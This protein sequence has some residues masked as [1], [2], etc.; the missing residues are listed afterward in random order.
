MVLSRGKARVRTPLRGG[1]SIAAGGQ[2]TQP[3]VHAKEPAGA[4]RVGREQ[5]G[6][7]FGKCA[8]RTGRV[9]TTKATHPQ[10]DLH[11]FAQQGPVSGLTLVTAVPRLAPDAARWTMR[12]ATHAVGFQLERGWIN[13]VDPLD[14]T[15]RKKMESV[16]PL[17][18]LNPHQMRENQNQGKIT[19]AFCPRQAANGVVLG[20]DSEC[21]TH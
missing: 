7:T 18:S 20:N 6:Q 1:E 12:A 9:V 2:P 21:A 4:P 3:S 11:R 5:T 19:P 8:A 10:D 15:A 13:P 16:H 14:A 17:P